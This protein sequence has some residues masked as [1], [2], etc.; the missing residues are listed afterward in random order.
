MDCG[1]LRP[2]AAKNELGTRNVHLAWVTLIGAC[3]TD[4]GGPHEVVASPTTRAIIAQ[5][6]P[7]H[8]ATKSYF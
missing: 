2:G 3:Y 8:T 6:K 4:R 5:S 7:R 1:M